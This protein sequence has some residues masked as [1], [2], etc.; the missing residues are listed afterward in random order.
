MMQLADFTP[1][2]LFD[3]VQIVL[4]FGEQYNLSICFFD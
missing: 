1:K 2:S 3:G 4:E